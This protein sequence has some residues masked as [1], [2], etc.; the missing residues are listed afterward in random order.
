MVGEVI[1]PSGG[2][3]DYPGTAALI[4]EGS[5]QCPIAASTFLAGPV[6]RSRYTPTF[7]YPRK[8]SWDNGERRIICIVKSAA[9]SKLRG[10]AGSGPTT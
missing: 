6:D 9:G 2:N 7:Y 1:D 10:S 4:T 3:A 8:V 5:S